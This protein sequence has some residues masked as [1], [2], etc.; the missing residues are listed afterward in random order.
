MTETPAKT[1]APN[2]GKTVVSALSP[3]TGEVV[4]VVHRPPAGG[5]DVVEV[6]PGSNVKFDFPTVD[7]KTLVLDVDLVL[8]FPDGGKIIL[9]GYAFG[10]VTVG[11]GDATF[12]DRTL[13]SQQLLAKISDLRIT[14]D[15][16]HQSLG[17]V[18][19]KE[20]EKKTEADKTA[21]DAPPPSPPAVP[22]STSS[23][24]TGVADFDKAPEDPGDKSPRKLADDVVPASSGAPPS[25]SH[26][27]DNTGNVSAAKLTITL[28]GVSGDKVTTLAGGG[29]EIR[30]APS[31]TEATT[32]SAFAVQQQTK[33]LVGTDHSDVIYVADPARMPTGTFERLIDIKATF[34]DAGVV[35]D[36]A[37]IT[38]LPAGFAINN[39]VHNG[40]NWE[41]TL[42]PLD[43]NHLQVELVYTLPTDGTKPDV[44]GF[45]S[46]FSLNVLFSSTAT[47]HL[48]SGS[49]TFVVRNIASEADVTI[50]SAD[51]QSKIYALNSVPPGTNVSA[52]AG[53]DTVYAGPGHD[54]LDGG[55]GNNLVSYIYSNSGV[56][57]DLSGGT[58]K[59]GAAEGDVLSN[60]TSIEGSTLADKLTG[61]G[62]DNTFFGSGGGDTIIG[63][64]GVDTV[65][66][67]KST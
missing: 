40:N 2:D 31:V 39:A 67:S 56:T 12:T 7:V 27:S 8:V 6:A 45:L 58:G 38:N 60:F 33:S 66:Y 17:S 28:L 43:P 57:V 30:G 32:N 64:G 61:T 47:S 63:N 55:A 49:Q 48:Y 42:N 22:P 5:I 25:A 10:L 46:N 51:G 19:E 54:T 37:T 23:K 13:T 21:D 50:T 44:N 16:T 65:D 35:A 52:G 18:A 62:G 24:F 14:E 59:G 20:G 29:Q 4:T 1:P 34:P 3:P 41:I 9:P 36:K 11:T 15:D 53:D 26:S